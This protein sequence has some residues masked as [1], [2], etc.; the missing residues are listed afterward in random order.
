M[1]VPDPLVEGINRLPAGT[2]FWRVRAVHGNAFGPWSA[3]VSFRVNPLPAIPTGMDLFWILADPGSVQGGNP[4]VGPHRSQHA[5]AGRW[6]ARPPRQ[7]LSGL[8]VRSPAS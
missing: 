6:H 8:R 1:V 7:R 5:R 3:G 4:T 2:Y